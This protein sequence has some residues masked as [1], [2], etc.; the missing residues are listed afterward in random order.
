M[1]VSD[2]SIK[3]PTVVAVDKNNI[4]FYQ[5]ICCFYCYNK[6]STTKLLNYLY[7]SIF[8]NYMLCYDVDYNFSIFYIRILY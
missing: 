2:K 8:M 5:L 7:L 6:M 4:S 1:G 3:C